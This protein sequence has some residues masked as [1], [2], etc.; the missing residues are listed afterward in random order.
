MPE[1]GGWQRV[2]VLRPGHEVE[3]VNLAARG[4][5]LRSSARLK[6]GLRSELQL[7]GARR[8]AMRGRIDRARV[9][10][11]EPLRYE[12]AMLFDEPLALAG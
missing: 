3:V 7:T 12:A 5:L 10:R 2:A 8:L 6:P 11:L 9:I 1:D 4:A